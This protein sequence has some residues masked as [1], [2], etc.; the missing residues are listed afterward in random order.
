MAPLALVAFRLKRLVMGLLSGGALGAAEIL[1]RGCGAVV[2]A[3]QPSLHA[4]A[5]PTQAIIF[6]IALGPSHYVRS[7]A[8]VFELVQRV[9]S[10]VFGA[11]PITSRAF[12]G[13]TLQALGRAT[14]WEGATK[15]LRPQ[16]GAVVWLRCQAEISDYI[17]FQHPRLVIV[18]G[19]WV[20]II[21]KFEKVDFRYSSMLAML[22][23]L[24]PLAALQVG[25]GSLTPTP[26]PS[27]LTPHP[28]NR[29]CTTHQCS[30]MCRPCES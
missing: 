7:G 12:R 15:P 16:W 25:R 14:H 17:P 19:C 28:N 27:P 4:V 21:C 20:D 1:V 6:L 29:R 10:A 8:H 22:R 5:F 13:V 30:G 3:G 26:S 2:A 23:A 24:R 11:P 18:I 9:E